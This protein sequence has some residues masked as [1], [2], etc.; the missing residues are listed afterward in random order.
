MPIKKVQSEFDKLSEVL[1]DGVVADECTAGELQ[2]VHD[3]L[4]LA[5]RSRDPAQLIRDKKITEQLLMFE[6]TNPVVGKVVKD[7]IN[8]LSG[9]GI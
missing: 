9:M 7:L 3:Q 2:K 5:I 6:E 8:A 4:Q 1:A